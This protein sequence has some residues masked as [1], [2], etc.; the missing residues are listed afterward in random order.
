MTTLCW[1]KCAYCVLHHRLQT[2][3]KEI[4]FNEQLKINSHPQIFRYVQR[5]F[6][7]PHWPKFSDFFDLRLQ[8]VFV[9]HA[10]HK[11]GKSSPQNFPTDF[12]AVSS[13]A[14]RALQYH[15][16]YTIPLEQTDTEKLVNRRQVFELLPPIFQKQIWRDLS[17]E[18]QASV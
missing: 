3:V 18:K 15:R 10:L 11:R 6:C 5:I 12:G 17:L 7:L 13:K 2:P 1:P 14:G 4:P 16:Y 9:L 8:W